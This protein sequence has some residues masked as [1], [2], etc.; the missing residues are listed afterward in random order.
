MLSSALDVTHVEMRPRKRARNQGSRR[1]QSSAA[2]AADEED[3]AEG[4]EE[5]SPVEESTCSSKSEFI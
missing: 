3:A 5:E 2:E 4:G 1:S